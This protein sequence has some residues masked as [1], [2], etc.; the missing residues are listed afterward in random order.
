VELEVDTETGEITLLGYV[1]GQDSG[2]VVNPQVLKNQV[3]GGAICGAGFAIHESLA[4][5]RETGRIM[6]GN[7][8]GRLQRDGRLAGHSDDA[9]ACVGGP[10]STLGATG[11]EFAQAPILVKNSIVAV[12]LDRRSAGGP[13]TGAGHR[14]RRKP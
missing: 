1:A 10:G 13:E 6:N 14:W 5:D 12:R 4:F 9:R 7:R 3:I 2:T 11:R 8:T